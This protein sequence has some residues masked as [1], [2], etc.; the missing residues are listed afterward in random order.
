[1]PSKENLILQ[2]ETSSGGKTF[3]IY[4]KFYERDEAVGLF[5]AGLQLGPVLTFPTFAPVLPNCLFEANLRLEAAQNSTQEAIEAV[6]ALDYR[7]KDAK[8]GAYL[9]IT[10]TKISSN[11][12]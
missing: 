3:S 1:M 8:F 9:I 5:P 11:A 10:G 6:S 7:L 4:A 2:E 12:N